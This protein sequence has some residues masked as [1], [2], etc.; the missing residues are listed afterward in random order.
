MVFLLFSLREKQRMEE[1]VCEIFSG[2]KKAFIFA[3]SKYE[4][5]EVAQ[6]VRAHDS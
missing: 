4:D 6:L 3:R 1:K 2:S 5:G